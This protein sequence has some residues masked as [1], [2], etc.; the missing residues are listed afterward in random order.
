[1]YLV[2]NSKYKKE[3]VEKLNQLPSQMTKTFADD[4]DDDD[5]EDDDDVFSQTLRSL[6]TIR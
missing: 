6:S 3:L 4:D 5:G 1:M 2:I